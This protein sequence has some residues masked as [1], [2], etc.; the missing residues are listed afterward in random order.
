M[1]CG[2]FSDVGERLLLVESGSIVAAANDPNQTFGL[3]L[4]S[5]ASWKS[6]ALQFRL[7]S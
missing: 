4:Y 2:V 5:V 6:A 3:G 1:H 7:T